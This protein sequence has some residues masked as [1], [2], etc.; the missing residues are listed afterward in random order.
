MITINLIAKML[1][2]NE[3]YT[4]NQVAQD[5]CVYEYCA[6]NQIVNMCHR[7]LFA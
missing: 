5:D 7:I 2:L 1:D 6:T 3:Y 4:T